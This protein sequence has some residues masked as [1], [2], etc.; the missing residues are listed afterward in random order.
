MKPV[1]ILKHE[2][3]SREGDSML[4]IKASKAMPK[5][6]RIGNS[7]GFVIGCYLL[8]SIDWREGDRISY[9]YDPEED[10]LR[11]ENYTAQMRREKKKNAIHRKH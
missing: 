11:V 3:L 4:R 7:V 5:L 1:V 8:E 10:E 6:Y 2:A 9:R